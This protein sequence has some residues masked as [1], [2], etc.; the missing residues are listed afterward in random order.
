VPGTGHFLPGTRGLQVTK[1]ISLVGGS[2]MPFI[3]RCVK[4]QR[5]LRVLDRLQDRL[6]RCPACQAK[7]VARASGS[8]AVAATPAMAR[9]VRPF[10]SPSGS[11]AVPPSSKVPLS[12]P[13]PNA[14]PSSKVPTGP[15]SRVAPG[16]EVT[17]DHGEDEFMADSGAMNAPPRPLDLDPTGPRSSKSGVRRRRQTPLVNVFATLGGVLLLTTL[18]ALGIAFWVNNKV[19]WLQRTPA[20]VN[21]AGR[22]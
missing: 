22:L 5:K 8:P 13:A 16:E 12:R 19:Q 17:V 2:S 6:V 1:R 10:N 15:R 11:R 21:P 4:C 18:L 9:P 3:I 20:S 14:P 7:F